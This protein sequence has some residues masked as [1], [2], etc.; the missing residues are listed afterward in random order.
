[1][2]NLFHFALH[3]NQTENI[4]QKMF[5]FYKQVLSADAG[6]NQ[7]HVFAKVCNTILA[8]E[9]QKDVKPQKLEFFG[10]TDKIL[11]SIENNCSLHAVDF[12][13]TE[14]GITV[15]D[16]SGNSLFFEKQTHKNNQKM[17][18][19]LQLPALDLEKTKAF[20][21]RHFETKSNNDDSGLN[22]HFF[23]HELHFVRAEKITERFSLSQEELLSGRKKHLFST[24]HFG[25]MDLTKDEIH[26]LI[27]G[28]DDENNLLLTPTLANKGTPH[29]EIY[30]FVQDPNGYLIELRHFN[31]E[32]S[33]QDI[34]KLAQ[35][36][37]NVTKEDYE[38]RRKRLKC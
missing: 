1:M 30:T 29:E 13:K 35:Q 23:G 20:Y 32:I 6:V 12:Q 14:K 10:V 3:I 21:Q 18:L 26:G 7:D 36:N 2:A 9:P 28:F 37:L 34:D 17:G 22:V 5:K 4:A 19:R 38:F 24:Q 33:L 16:P 27:N 8:F 25:V 31:P 11:N 15:T